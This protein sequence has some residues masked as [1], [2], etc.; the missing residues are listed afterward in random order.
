VDDPGAGDDSTWSKEGSDI[1]SEA[2]IPGLEDEPASQFTAGKTSTFP[3]FAP[4]SASD[5]ATI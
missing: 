2:L 5:M 1:E 3:S 4:V